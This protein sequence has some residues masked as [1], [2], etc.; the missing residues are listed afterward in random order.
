MTEKIL[1]TGGAGYIGSL[2]AINLIKEGYEGK[3]YMTR[4]TVELAR[5]IWDDAYNIMFY[6]N[7]K[8]QTLRIRYYKV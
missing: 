1:I 8:Y 7:K 2:L 6:N 3:I 5:L 4:A